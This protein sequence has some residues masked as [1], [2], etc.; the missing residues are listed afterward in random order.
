MKQRKLELIIIAVVF[1]VGL[2]LIIFQNF[3]NKIYNSEVRKFSSLEEMKSFLA[4]NEG[5]Y[6][7]YGGGIGALFDKSANAG[8]AGAP[9]ASQESGD[10]GGSDYWRTNIQVEGVDEPDIVKNDGEYIYLVNGNIVR[11]VKAFPADDMKLISEI[12]LSSQ[13]RGIFIN[14]DRLI[15]FTE[16][17]EYVESGT[18]CLYDEGLTLEKTFAPCGGYGKQRTEILVYDVENRETPVLETSTNAD[19]YYTDSRM[20]GDYV[21]LISSKYISLNSFELPAFSINGEEK[22]I[23]PSDVWY[24]PYAD[25][26]YIFTSVT[27]LN[28]ETEEINNEVYLLGSTM[29]V[30]VSENNIY[31]TA[32]KRVD[33][34]DYLK[35]YVEE[36]LAEV[37]PSEKYSDALDILDDENIA[38]KRRAID[39]I[40][41]EHEKSLKGNEKSDFAKRLSE[42]LEGF[43]REIAREMDKTIVHKIEIEDGEIVYATSGEVYG[44]V[45]NQFSMDEFDGYFRI[46][47][48]SGNSWDGT[49]SNN[50][51]ILDDDLNVVGSLENLAS[52]ESIYSARFIGDRAY[53]VTFKKIDP[54]FVIDLKDVENPRVLGYLKIP[55]YSDYLH[56]YDETHIIGIGKDAI[57]ASDSGAGAGSADFAWYQGL[58]IAIFDVSDVENPRESAKI[59]VGDRGTDSAALYEHKAFLFNREKNLLVIPINVA[60][61]NESFYEGKEIPDFAYGDIVWK[62]AYVFDIRE[63]EISIRGRVTHIDEENKKEDYWY[64]WNEEIQRSLY[65]DDVLYTISNAKIKA[66]DLETVAEINSIELPVEDSPRYVLY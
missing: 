19:G 16:S 9:A 38:S 27:S 66:N 45:L 3:E 59:T 20:I 53:L 61:I 18:P 56:P 40:V 14:K 42:N 41:F 58:K 23:A 21:Y 32:Q 57:D 60:D 4:S 54:F 22:L 39:K 33:G 37:L 51:F 63:D 2:F 10:S 64:D 52:G 17:Y 43:E 35:R 28:I 12:N 65:I 5:S 24:Y 7:S 1:I 55:G 13:V 47:T 8:S 44:S 6:S 15:I 62:G 30:Y 34:S 25:E 50:L 36:V 46:A 26:S 31:L 11:I 29:N 48:T 49:S